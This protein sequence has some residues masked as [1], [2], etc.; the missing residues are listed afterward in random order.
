MQ[1]DM[2]PATDAHPQLQAIETIQS[3]DPLAIHQPPFAPQQDPNPQVPKPRPGMGQIPDAQPQS[4]LILRATGSLPRR[5]TELRQATGP[6]A[7]DLKRRPKPLGEF[8]AAG[9]P[10]TFFRSASDSMC[11]SS[12]RSATNRFKRLFS[13]SSCRSRRSSLTPKWA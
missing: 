4:R 9:G 13:S 3:A 6:Q 8:A 11:L 12:D 2:F 10:Q 1:R 5:S 7:T